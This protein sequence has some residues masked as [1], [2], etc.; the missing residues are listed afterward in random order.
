M[1]DKIISKLQNPYYMGDKPAIVDLGITGVINGRKVSKSA[2]IPS[3]QAIGYAQRQELVQHPY[4]TIPANAFNNAGEIKFRIK[5]NSMRR[6]Q[7]GKLRFQVT[8]TSGN[9]MVLCPTTHFLQYI[10]MRGKGG[11]GDKINWA[12]SD[13]ELFKICNLLSTEQ[14]SLFRRHL[15]ISSNF[16]S[17]SEQTHAANEVKWYDYEFLINPLELGKVDFTLLNDDVMLRLFCR[18]GIVVSGSGVPSLTDLQFIAYESD[19]NGNV[20]YQNDGRALLTKYI[21]AWQFL[22]QVQYEESYTFAPGVLTKVKLQSFANIGPCPFLFFQIRASGYSAANNGILNTYDLGRNSLIDVISNTNT[23][24]LCNGSPQSADM[25]R[26]DLPARHFSGNPGFY[27]NWFTIPFC[28][29][30]ADSFKGNVNGYLD[31]DQ[32]YKFLNITPDSLGQS[33]STLRVFTLQGRA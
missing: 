33:S 13:C 20:T 12:Y 28:A 22:D 6:F 15:N 25:F 11:S 30:V 26:W 29:S 5:M 16:N 2:M 27:K 7:G 32:D 4:E 10:E 31:F 23:S 9:P 19:D 3:N 1:S 18:S 24:L 21:S 8:E 17:T 14:F